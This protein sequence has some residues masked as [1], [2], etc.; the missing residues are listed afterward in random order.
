V[1]PKVFIIP[2][3]HQDAQTTDKKANNFADE[4]SAV[5]DGR[6]TYLSMR[7]D[8]AILVLFDSFRDRE[9]KRMATIF[10]NGI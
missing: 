9:C 1:Q 8:R 6:I 5:I 2:L 7:L 4:V 10:T 3:H